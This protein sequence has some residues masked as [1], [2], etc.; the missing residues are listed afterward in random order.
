[1]HWNACQ[2]GHMY[3]KH[4]FP[5]LAFDIDNIRPISPRWNKK[6][7]DNIADWIDNTPLTNDAKN[8]LKAISEDKYLKTQTKDNTFYRWQY[9][10]YKALNIIEQ[11]RLGI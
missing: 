7:A 2:W 8:T 9:E 6:Q 5:Q 3:P 1:M 11:I 4:N 10:K